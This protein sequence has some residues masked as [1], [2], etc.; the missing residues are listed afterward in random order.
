[1]DFDTTFTLTTDLPDVSLDVP[2]PA[3][4]QTFSAQYLRE[5]TFQDAEKQ[6]EALSQIP[7]LLT[8][9]VDDQELLVNVVRLLMRGLPRATAIAITQS[10]PMLDEQDSEEHAQVELLHWDSS[11]LSAIDFRPSERLIRHAISTEQ[12]VVHAWSRS[13]QNDANFTQNHGLDW[14]FCTP[15]QADSRKGWSI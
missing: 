12:A 7:D 2:I 3:T 10:E 11:K 5:S 8:G 14:A 6:I 4:E 15:I 9:A 13:R 1:M